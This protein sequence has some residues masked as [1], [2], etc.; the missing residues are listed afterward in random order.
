MRAE[1]ISCTNMPTTPSQ[2][3]SG[4]ADW[5]RL[6]VPG[7]IFVGLIAL[8]W[9]L[10][11]FQLENSQQLE[12]TV[13]RVSGDPWLLP[14]FAVAYTVMVALAF[15]ASPLAYA[16]GT[17]FGFWRGSIIVWVAS[18]IG[19]AGGYWLARGAW[20]GMAKRMLGRHSNMLTQ[21]KGT[22]P[23]LTT[24]RMRILP[25]VPFGGFTL[26][27]AVSKLSFPGFM[28]GTALGAVPST[29][30]AVYVGDRVMAG[31]RGGS[32]HPFII[33][34]ALSAALLLL[35]F[36]IPKHLAR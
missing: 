20:S 11:Y 2:Q 18:L 26:A 9:K 10:G 35:S 6:I 8:A 12:T 19:A 22:D 30:A 24:L 7:I 34:G 13:H 3:S 28:V 29:V 36:A 31:I 32:G 4:F 5:L 21:L 16:A 15:P 17:L 27:A 33:A 1:W 23:F 25:I 14:I